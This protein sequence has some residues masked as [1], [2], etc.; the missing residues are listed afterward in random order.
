MTGL[1]D[2]AVISGCYGVG[3]IGWLDNYYLIYYPF[4][5]YVVPYDVIFVIF[6]VLQA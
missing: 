5:P 4:L 6:Q 2:F 1:G 3:F